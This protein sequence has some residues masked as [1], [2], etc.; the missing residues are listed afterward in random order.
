MNQRFAKTD[1]GR[2]EIKTR[3]H[4]LSR[5]ARNL[6]LIIDENHTGGNWVQLV[7][8]ATEDDLKQ[9]IADGLIV[10]RAA[11][12]QEA[13]AAALPLADALARLSYDQLYSLMTSQAKARLG[14]IKGFTFVLEVEKCANL[15]E[16]R[17]L[18]LRFLSM[19]QE[20]QGEAVAKQ[21]RMAL[22][23]A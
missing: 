10:A 18:A 5:H 22:G 16:L 14:L 12:G 3:A 6:L 19:V 11:Q 20:Q 17:K 7:H 9:L 8:G 23:A 2:E 21:M 13:R 15:D 4:K 1:A